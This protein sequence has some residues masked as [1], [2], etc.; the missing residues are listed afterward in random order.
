MINLNSVQY[1]ILFTIIAYLFFNI[2]SFI[3]QL[4]YEFIKSN[5]YKV[6][7]FSDPV[8][9][10]KFDNENITCV[11]SDKGIDCKFP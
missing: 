7:A 10:T 5:C 1:I 11:S 2:I 4:N 8:C 3:S 6:S 9:I